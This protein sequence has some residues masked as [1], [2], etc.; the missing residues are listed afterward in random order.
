MRSKVE[1]MTNVARLIRHYFD[2]IVALTPTS[3]TNDFI[4]ANN[5]LLQSAK[6]KA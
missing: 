1:P 4:E 2:G 5:G 3:R 6:L